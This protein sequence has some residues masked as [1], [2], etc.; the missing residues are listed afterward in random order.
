MD[1]PD[2]RYTYFRVRGTGDYLIERRDGTAT[3]TL[4]D[5]TASPAV[6]CGGSPDGTARNTLEIGVAASTTRFFM[7]GTEVEALPTESVKPYGLVGLRV[8][9]MLDIAV[10]D[11]RVGERPPVGETTM[12]AGDTA[13][14]R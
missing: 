12:A 6:R 7:N 8:N 4:V 14:L 5:W 3:P 2:Q 9:H 10:R 11:Y 13:R 1:D